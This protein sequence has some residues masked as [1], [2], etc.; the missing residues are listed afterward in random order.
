MAPRGPL[1]RVDRRTFERQVQEGTLG[2]PLLVAGCA[3]GASRAWTSSYL[4]EHWPGTCQMLSRNLTAGLPYIF[5]SGDT[6]TS[7]REQVPVSQALEM[8]FERATTHTAFRVVAKRSSIPGKLLG[9]LPECPGFD[10]LTLWLQSP[11]TV[12]PFHYDNV[13][14]LLIQLRGE[15][16]VQF[17]P[18]REGFHTLLPESVMT[19]RGAHLSTVGKT[20]D[21]RALAESFLGGSSPAPVDLVLRP[22]E[23]LYVPAFWWHHV[24]TLTP[25]I[26]LSLRKPLQGTE[27]L[28]PL[29]VRVIADVLFSPL[30]LIRRA[31][32]SS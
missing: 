4:K 13:H 2:Q 15:K 27:R 32:S 14:G 19:G 12:T 1:E 21:S 28:H 22:G 29:E 20:T 6:F 31:G 5:A 25:S 9:E 18:P 10:R 26:S 3:E 7:V 16:R 23:T 30:R 24:E 17:Y 8:I 11:G